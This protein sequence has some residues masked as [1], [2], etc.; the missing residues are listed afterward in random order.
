MVPRRGEAGTV[1]LKG[2]AM[3]NSGTGP[4]GLLG[5]RGTNAGNS[6][7]PS[8]L[9]CYRE[10]RGEIK[11]G[12]EGKRRQVRKGGRERGRGGISVYYP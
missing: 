7:S 3:H 5:D 9:T 6:P 10:R 1:G 8:L 4:D 12:W 2:V 11:T